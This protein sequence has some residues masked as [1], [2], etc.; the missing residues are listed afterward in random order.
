[1]RLHL[2]ANPFIVS[3]SRG[4]E[5]GITI[6]EFVSAEIGLVDDVTVAVVW[7]SA[8]TEA[9]VVIIEVNGAP[10]AIASA[11]IQGDPTI[12]YYV[13]QTPHHGATDVLTVNNNPVTNNIAW[14]TFT[15]TGTITQL[16]STITGVGTL[17]LSEVLVDDEIT[18]AGIDGVVQ[19]I[20]S[21]LSLTV[22]SSATVAVGVTY[23]ITRFL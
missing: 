19:S 11:T 12:V 17:F 2:R 7:D 9:P 10:Q 13:I 3:L 5:A 8:V 6:P 14:F 18:A 4:K 1:M 16:V 23:E 22:D 21:D 20:E 15:G